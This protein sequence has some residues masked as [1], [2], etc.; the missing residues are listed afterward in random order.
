M[1]YPKRYRVNAN[2][3][4]DWLS[5]TEA[6][7]IETQQN[8]GSRS[9]YRVAA[10]ETPMATI[11]ALNIKVF[12]HLLS[13]KASENEVFLYGQEVVSDHTHLL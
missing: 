4:V 11:K 1:N 9:V 2:L 8:L 13:C 3:A 5:L 6:A 10:Q 12:G 7:V